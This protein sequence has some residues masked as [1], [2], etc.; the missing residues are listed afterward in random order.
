MSGTTGCGKTVALGTIAAQWD[1]MYVGAD[2]L[3]RTFSANFGEQLAKQER[4]RDTNK[5]LALDDI[6]T[7]IDDTRMLPTLLEIINARASAVYTPTVIATN[8]TKKDFADRY[9]NERLM[10]RMA[11]VQWTTVQGEDLRR[12]K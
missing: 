1:T 8:L 4:I 11:R 9:K 2:D 10:S 7:E 12:Q 3:C 5:L 6:G